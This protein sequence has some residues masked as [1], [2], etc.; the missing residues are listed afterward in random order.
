MRLLKY[1]IF[2]DWDIHKTYFIIDITIKLQ[3]VHLASHKVSHQRSVPFRLC[4]ANG[5]VHNLVWE[6]ALETQAPLAC[7][8]PEIFSVF[9][10]SCCLVPLLSDQQGRTAYNNNQLYHPGQA[11]S[12]L[13][14]WWGATQTEIFP[15]F[16]VYIYKCFITF[17]ANLL[18]VS[19]VSNITPIKHL[20]AIS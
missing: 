19:K 11:L 6:S 5:T 2:T 8:W 14:R 20:L 17:R 7:I 15:V 16:L 4:M 18:T 9:I 13:C 12:P 3:W 1:T 10:H